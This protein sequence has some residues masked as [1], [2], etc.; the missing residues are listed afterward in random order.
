MF[1]KVNA[2]AFSCSI[3]KKIFQNVLPICW[4]ERLFADLAMNHMA[5]K[6][7]LRTHANKL[8]ARRASRAHEID[9]F[10][11]DQIEGLLPGTQCTS[12][13]HHASLPVVATQPA[14]IEVGRRR[15]GTLCP[16]KR[17]RRSRSKTV[18]PV[19][20]QLENAVSWPRGSG[21]REAPCSR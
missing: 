13:T 11:H 6:S 3:D 4:W 10:G 16:P 1:H 14:M 19:P 12:S 2:I 18:T 15:R 5:Q 21:R 7:R 8:V 9:S 17:R 20:R